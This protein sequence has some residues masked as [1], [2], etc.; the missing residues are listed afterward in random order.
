[1]KKLKQFIL[2][3][4]TQEGFN[5]GLFLLIIALQMELNGLILLAILLFFVG[6]VIFHVGGI[7][8]EFHKKEM[9]LLKFGLMSFKTL[10]LDFSLATIG[11]SQSYKS[12]ILLSFGV[13]LMVCYFAI[14]WSLHEVE[15]M[16]D[17]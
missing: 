1:M 8:L 2:N 10:S 16:C 14:I 5:I 12:F 15:Q 17:F 7:M 9:S 11:L 3:T 13:G 4:N 6:A